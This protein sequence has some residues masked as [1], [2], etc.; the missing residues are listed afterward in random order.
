MIEIKD[1]IEMQEAEDEQDEHEEDILRGQLVQIY[2]DLDY[3]YGM[4]C[5]MPNSFKY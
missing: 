3:A 4:K 2:S 5:G 1:L